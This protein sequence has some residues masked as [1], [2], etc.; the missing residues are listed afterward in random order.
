MTD[1]CKH[2]MDN[3][4]RS[5]NREYVIALFKK[6]QHPLSVEEIY[7][8]LLKK[9]KK[10][11][12]STVYRIIDKL[13][14][15]G[16]I[17]ESLKDGERALYELIENEHKHYLICTKCKKMVSLDMCPFGDFEQHLIKETGF[18]ITGH[19]FEIFGVC[20]NCK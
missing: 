11:A 6:A 15:F 7:N 1:F 10:L 4:R 20:P 18:K 14:E 3:C 13:L 12:L 5:K 8:V 16:I 17:H 9:K 19:R 2:N